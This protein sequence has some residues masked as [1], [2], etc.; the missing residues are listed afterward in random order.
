[1]CSVWMAM[2]SLVAATQMYTRKG[3]VMLTREEIFEWLDTHPTNE[4]AVVHDDNDHIKVLF[5]FN[6][7]ENKD[8]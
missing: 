3:L 8:G 1:M 6:E 5:W 7:V 2:V 4:W